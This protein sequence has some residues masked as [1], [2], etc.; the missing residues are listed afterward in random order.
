MA[1]GRVFLRVRDRQILKQYD[2][3]TTRAS[4][5]LVVHNDSDITPDIGTSLVFVEMP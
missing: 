3:A 5:K 1:P 4:S 2:S